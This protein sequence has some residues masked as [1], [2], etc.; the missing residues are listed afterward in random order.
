MVDRFGLI[1]F[2]I[3]VLGDPLR[4]ML[5]LLLP[6]F[7]RRMHG[8][9]DLRQQCEIFGILIELFDRDIQL[10]RIEVLRIDAVDRKP[11]E[12]LLDDIASVL[13][14]QKLQRKHLVALHIRIF[15]H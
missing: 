12:D 9:D 14:V 13:F 7:H 1:V 6:R 8:S 2:H 3:Q 11:I 10:L 5:S 4:Q 15:R